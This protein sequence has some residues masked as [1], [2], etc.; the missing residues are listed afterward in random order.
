MPSHK[1]T[2]PPYD[3]A[4][5]V[6][7]VGA[8]FGGCYALHE[9]RR[10]GYTAKI[11]E[12]EA[13][14]GGVWH[15]NRY[16]GVRVDSETPV[17]Q[18][19]L[20]NVTDSFNFTERFP[21]GEELRRY[22]A[23]LDQTLDLRKDTIF[24]TRVIGVHFDE[25][26]T[27]WSF[28]TE[29]GLRATSRYVIFASGSTNKAFIPN[30]PGIERF[31]GT[32]IH[33]SSWLQNL[34]VKGKKIGIIGQ[35]ASG[36]Q[37]LQTLAKQDCEVTVFIRTPCTAMPMGQR[38]ISTR[39]SEELKN[40]YDGIFTKAK[41]NSS[42]GY[43]Y[44]PCHA[45][46]N[47]LSKEERHQY[48]EKLWAR[49]GYGFLSSNFP[50]NM[51]SKEANAEVYDFWVNKVRARMTDPVKRDIVAPLKQFQWIGT[52]RPS[53]EMNYYEMLDRP[54]VKLVDLKSTP[55][56]EFTSGGITTIDD[57]AHELDV[58]VFATGYDSVTGSLYDMNI[59]DKG[60]NSLQKKWEEGIKTYLGM[61]VPG[62]PNAFI[63]YGP[64]APTALANGPPFLELQVE[65]VT[66]LLD[67]MKKDKV[68]TVEVSS[69]AAEAW[70][71]ASSD[72][73]EMLLHRET[74]SWW[75]GA[76]IPG[77]RREPLIWHG[78]IPAWWKECS[79]ALADWSKFT[80]S[81]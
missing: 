19:S 75:N 3:V 1:P 54:N 22:F 30:F 5:D 20:P 46:Y 73:F 52:K 12:A 60:G 10:Q 11:L 37:I 70:G 58:V 21:D 26:K 28:S 44:N 27:T 51:F 79:N 13:D 4:V 29:S 55:I 33:P 41:Y 49:G 43:A 81:K 56:K 34:D 24:N 78:G 14:F 63:L 23:H 69:E 2:P 38:P 65:W 62:L 15:F 17:Y 50:E 42:A 47:D 67:N 72:T 64:Q 35:G 8:G 53:L 39:E 74:P 31:N 71:Q 32:L 57:K 40:L 6:V 16:P 80:V 25:T 36:V 59:N 9:M 61:M 48:Y 77:K 45:S 68:Q 76:N 18:L 66:K 7:I